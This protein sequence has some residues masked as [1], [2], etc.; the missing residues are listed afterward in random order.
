[1]KQKIS[2]IGLGYVGL[3]LAVE[4]GKLFDTLGFDI[5]REKIKNFKK[6]DIQNLVNKKKFDNSSKLSFSY[7][8]EDLRDTKIFIVTVP[9]PI[10]KNKKPDL[11][12]LITATKM[13]SKYVTKNNT[14]IFE[15]TVFPGVTE[16]IC[17][18]II[19]KTTKL[20][21][22]KDFYIGYSPERISP[23][24]KNDI[25]EI[26]KIVSGSNQKATTIVYNLY[27]KII[28]AKLY[29]A[30][31][32][33]VAECSKLIE[34]AQRDINISFINEVS[35]ICSKL[36][37]HTSDVL[38]A[39][40][41]KWN[42]LDFKPGLVG[43]HCISVDPFYLTHI[44]KKNKYSPKVILS[45]R[46]INDNMGI[47]IA[48]VALNK[49]KEKKIEFKK[50]K[51]GVLG[52]TFKEDCGDIRGSKILDTI[53]ILRK[54]KINISTYD[55]VVNL[56]ELKKVDPNLKI[57]KLKDKFDILIIAVAHKEFLKVKY[58]QVK[59]L[60]KN[61][62]SVLFDIKSILD[63]SILNKKKIKFWS[64]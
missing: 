23:G 24:D 64:L 63:K 29:K 45:G 12:N 44:A 17:I 50:A 59:N 11:R 55:P 8:K 62:D 18:P 7:K 58:N 4:F 52:V 13:I 61:K 20:R 51:I 1:M 25:S 47:Y 57:K 38:A 37:I 56:N 60:L 27:N 9:T 34:N 30:K 5:N 22:N 10:Y 32:I 53:K 36:N 26:N 39:A 35:L 2:I 14:I 46:T 42:F 28:K 31:S 41:T 40:K 48:E 16:D 43:G 49:L 3:P 19:E 54:K 15:S 33:R 6:K 21:V